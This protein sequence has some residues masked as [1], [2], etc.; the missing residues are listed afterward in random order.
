MRK[1]RER[2]RHALSREMMLWALHRHREQLSLCSLTRPSRKSHFLLNANA[3]YANGMG[4]L[5]QPEALLLGVK[6]AYQGICHSVSL[7]PVLGVLRAWIS[8][9]WQRLQR[10]AKNVEA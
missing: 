4:L 5:L 7:D 6:A 10:L 1:A 8:S 9:P 2:R 3:E